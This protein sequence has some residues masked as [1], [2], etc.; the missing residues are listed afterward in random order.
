MARESQAASRLDRET[1]AAL[2]AVHETDG[3]ADLAHLTRSAAR[4]GLK[5]R[6]AAY[7]ERVMQRKKPSAS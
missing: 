6:I 1:V 5:A 3:A 7:R 4:P 2:H